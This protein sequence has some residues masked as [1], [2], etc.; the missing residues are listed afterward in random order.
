M[1]DRKSIKKKVKKKSCSIFVVPLWDLENIQC[2]TWE[3]PFFSRLKSKTLVYKSNKFCILENVFPKKKE[4]Q[5]G[6]G[7]V[8]K[9]KEKRI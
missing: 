9:E 1:N 2:G 4:F 6:E 7:R 3:L 5:G 8:K